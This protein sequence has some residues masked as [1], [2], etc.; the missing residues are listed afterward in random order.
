MEYSKEE[1]LKKKKEEYLK[2]LKEEQ[3]KLLFI[4]EL[5]SKL[6]LILEKEA[7]E[8]YYNIKSINP[9]LA[10]QILQYL[11]QLFNSG[12]LRKKLSDKEFKQLLEKIM[13]KKREPKIRFVRK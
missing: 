10:L 1:I 12:M 11:I 6:S 3:E 13:P 5:E 9:E 7:L 2:K 4:K 8:R